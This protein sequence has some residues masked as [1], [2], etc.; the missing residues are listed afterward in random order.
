VIA[1]A[2]FFSAMSPY[3]WLAAER[4]GTLISEAE[5]KPVFGGRVLKAHGRASWGLAEG[6]ATGMADCEA[7]ARRY[8]LGEMRWPDA[9]PS[10]GALVAR[11]LIYAERQ[12]RLERFAL[13]AMRSQFL[14]GRDLGELE[15]L[16]EVAS[17]VG[18][19]PDDAAAAVADL[20]IDAAMRA[21]SD[22]AI[23]RGV[24]GIPTALVGDT[25]FWGDDRLDEAAALAANAPQP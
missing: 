18:L 17:R 2:F 19:S 7:R 23:A 16:R 5:W 6:R 15:T 13:T 12:R 21:A 4:I 20:E 14:E 25:L 9:W 22:E 11:A 10:N 1:I 8:G 3:S 24:F